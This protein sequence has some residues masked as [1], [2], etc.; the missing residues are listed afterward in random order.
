MRRSTA[1]DRGSLL[2][3]DARTGD[4]NDAFWLAQTHFLTHQFAQAERILAL[5]RADGAERLADTSVACRYLAAQC[6]VRLGKW[7]EALELVGRGD[8]P[9][10]SPATGDDDV[11]TVH[12][13]EDEVE[14][15]ADGGVKFVAS[16][17]YLRGLIHLHLGAT[18]LAKLCLM[19][20]LARDVKCFDAFELL[21]GT[22]MMTPDEEWDFVQQLAYG[23]HTP[24]DAELVRMMYTL[25]LKKVRPLSATSGEG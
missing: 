25:R 4:P 12:E 24:D 22:E 9:W 13:E 7:D 14:G 6:Q 17:A 10:S 23:Q 8:D 2:T 5:P 20:A 3:D 1:S 15:T 11:R 21:V 16:I 19:D 18:D